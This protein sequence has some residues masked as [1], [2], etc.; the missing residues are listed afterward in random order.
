[1]DYIVCP[2]ELYNVGGIKIRYKI[3]KKQID[4]FNKKN[5]NFEIFKIDQLEGNIGPNDLKYIPIFFRPLTSKEYNLN[6]NVFYA[7]EAFYNS[8][9]DD[10]ELFNSNKEKEDGIDRIGKIPVQ[11]RGVGYHPK[12]FIPPKILKILIR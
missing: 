4:E 7:D 11:I 2:L 12:K 1:M 9:S 10:L 3:D 6:L 5:D 8:K